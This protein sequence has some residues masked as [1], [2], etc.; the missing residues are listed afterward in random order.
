MPKL[1]QETHSTSQAWAASGSISMELSP[2]PYTI[3]RLGLF[4]KAD[5]TTTSVT[6]FNDYWDRLVANLSLSGRGNTY[7]DFR[8]LRIAYHGERFR[9]VAPRRPTVIAGS[10]TNAIQWFGYVFHF[11]VVP[12][13]FNPNTGKYDDN[14]YDLTGGIPP[15]DKGNLT[16]TGAFAAAGAMG[17]SVTI[18]NAPMYVQLWGVQAQPGDDPAA[19]L[20]R[21][22]PNWQMRTPTPTATSGAYATQDNVPA[23]DFLH[24]MV[25]MMTNGSNAPRDDGVLGSFKIY[26]QLEAYDVLQ[27]DQYK[28]GEMASQLQ[29]SPVAPYSDDGSTLGVPSLNQVSDEGLLFL[30]LHEQAV[31]GHPLYGVDLRSVATGD[32]QARYGVDDATGITLDFLYYKY[33]LNMDHPA[34]RA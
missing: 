2:K 30:P 14:P 34:N 17:T 24:T 28:I 22:F 5:V 12:M 32:L 7:F 18:N 23:G 26:N 15:S 4:M 9:G 33:K 19:Y 29:L 25:V 20:P 3:T 16:L 13:K 21:A 11:G 27:F 10:Q 6:N 8:N 1:R 31:T